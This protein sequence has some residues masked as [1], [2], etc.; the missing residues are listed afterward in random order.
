MATIQVRAGDNLQS[1]VDA[2]QSGDELVLDAGAT[3]PVPLTLPVFAGTQPITI[4]SSAMDHLPEAGKR[5]DPSMARAMPKLTSKGVATSPTS[6]LTTQPGAHHWTLIGIEI[7]PESAATFMYDLVTLGDGSSAQNTLDAVP[8]DI[9]L[10]RCYLHTW[11]DQE[12]KRGLALNSAA[13]KVLGCWISGF[14]S[15][16]QDSQA[17]CGWNGP[18]P[19]TIENTYAEAAGENILFGGAPTAIPNLIPSDIAITNCDISKPLAWNPQAPQYAGK[20]YSVKNLL[21]L[22]SAQRVNISGNKLKNNW[23][24]AQTGGAF[25]ITPRG[26]QSGGPWCA[27]RDVQFTN[28]QLIGSAQGIMI[29]GS[30]SYS[31][32]GRAENLEIRN[33]LFVDVA[34]NNP[35]WGAFTSGLPTLFLLVTGL[36]GGVK[37]L[38]ID[39]NTCTTCLIILSGEGSHEGLTITNNAL[40]N[41]VYGIKAG[42]VEGGKKSLQSLDPNYK[43]AGNIIPGA[44]SR[45]Y[46]AGNFFP[47]T[48][49]E[50]GFSNAANGDYSLAAT[51]PYKGK[52]ADGSDPGYSGSAIPLPVAP[53]VTLSAPVSI[54]AGDTAAVAKVVV[55]AGGRLN[56]SGKVKLSFGLF[57]QPEQVFEQNLDAGGKAEFSLGA[58]QPGTG[59]LLATFPAQGEYPAAT[60]NAAVL[61][62]VGKLVPPTAITTKV[63]ITAPTWIAQGDKAA[64]ANVAVTAADGSVPSGSVRLSYG[65]FG[66]FEHVLL[67]GKTDYTLYS[68][69]NGDYSLQATYDAQGNYAASKSDPQ[70]LSVGGTQPPP[71]PAKSLSLKSIEIADEVGK[72]VFKFPP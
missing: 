2:S 17:I 6:V 7:L 51:S 29:L 9:T 40:N 5:I 36:A 58:L 3:F 45:Y 66:T 62:V 13:T 12:L 55:T 52:A 49:D 37:G 48:W 15:A 18:G 46:D 26:D 63:A 24:G 33:N 42:G 38:L 30:D 10:D 69:P 43:L 44:D 65:P 31:I 21:E 54:F 19:F 35:L 14:K 72:T 34:G 53:V 57:G 32:S 61:S 16:S 59:N 47:S 41:G 28:N 11:P 8:H 27:V 4:R 20:T 25:L 1:A 68:L 71:P 39:H 60:S 50:V 23:A 70:T 67:N 64:R 22:K 56:V